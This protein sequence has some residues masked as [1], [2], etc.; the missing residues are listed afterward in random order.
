MYTNMPIDKTTHITTITNS[1]YIDTSTTKKITE[2]TNILGQN[3]FQF[4][5]KVYK[6]KGGFTIGALTPAVLSEVDL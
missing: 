1:K 3:Y 4:Y 6:Q 5:K 2:L